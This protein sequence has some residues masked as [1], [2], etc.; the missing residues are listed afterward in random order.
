MVTNFLLDAVA[1]ALQCAIELQS[2]GAAFRTED[3]N[4]LLRFLHP[5]RVLKISKTAI[6]EGFQHAD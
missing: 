5:L 1:Y 2:V 3:L 4:R 6:L